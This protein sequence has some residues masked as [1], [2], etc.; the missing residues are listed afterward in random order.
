MTLKYSNGERRGEGCGTPWNSNLQK[1]KLSME[2]V[3]SWKPDAVEGP[4][5]NHCLDETSH[6]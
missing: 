3:L 6:S 1:L 4:E 2:A 5:K